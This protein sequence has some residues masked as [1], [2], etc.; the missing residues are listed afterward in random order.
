MYLSQQE[1]QLFPYQQDISLNNLVLP[2]VMLQEQGCS[3]NRSGLVGK[4]VVV[5]EVDRANQKYRFYTSHAQ[6]QAPKNVVEK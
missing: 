1:L 3:L 4:A 6:N 5:A 2:E